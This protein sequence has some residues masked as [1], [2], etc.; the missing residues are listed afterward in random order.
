[1]SDADMGLDST[2]IP[3]DT[4]VKQPGHTRLLLSQVKKLAIWRGGYQPQVHCARSKGMH[5]GL[6]GG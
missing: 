6:E 1:M 4:A 5:L 2:L 3:A